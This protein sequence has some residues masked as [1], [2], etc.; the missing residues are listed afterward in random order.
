MGRA[1]SRILT[2]S[3]LSA[4]GLQSYNVSA[5]WLNL[6]NF[7]LKINLEFGDWELTKKMV[8]IGQELYFLEVSSSVI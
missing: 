8:Q 5:T 3:S 2:T 6:N 1:F 7:S 4:A